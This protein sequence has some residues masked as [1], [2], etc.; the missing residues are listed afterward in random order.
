MQ[1]NLADQTMSMFKFNFDLDDLTDDSELSITP[2]QSTEL[3]GEERG[4]S[5]GKLPAENPCTEVSIQE[6]VR[7]VPIS[8][9][10][11]LMQREK[12]G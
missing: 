11:R 10:T 5:G 9:G 12:I 7:I 1:E 3:G 8:R 6:L 4:I 2:E